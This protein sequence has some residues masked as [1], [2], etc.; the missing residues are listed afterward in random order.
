MI[1]DFCES[2]L[3]FVPEKGEMEVVRTREEMK[4]RERVAVQKLILEKRLKQEET[5]RWRQTAAQVAISALPVVGAT[6]GRELFRAAL[7]RRSGCWGCGCL[8]LAASAAA[9]VLLAL[10]LLL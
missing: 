2:R 3:K 5:E 8:T 10:S 9:L 6:V 1:C 7:G 4:Y